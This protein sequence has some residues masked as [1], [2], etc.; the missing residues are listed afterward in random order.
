MIGIYTGKLNVSK[1]EE[2]FLFKKKNL[3]NYLNI[4]E[5]VHLKEITKL[6]QKSLE[7]ERFT[8][9]IGDIFLKELKIEK[10]IYI[11]K[12]S[13]SSYVMLEK[14]WNCSIKKETVFLNKKTEI[15]LARKSYLKTKE[16]KQELFNVMPLSFLKKVGPSKD[17]GL[18]VPLDFPREDFGFIMFSSRIA[19]KALAFKKVIWAIKAVKKITRGLESAWLKYKLGETESRLKK[20]LQEKKE[21]IKKNIEHQEEYFSSLSHEV[22]TPLSIIRNYL[23]DASE[24]NRLDLEAISRQVQSLNQLLESIIFLSK[25][26]SGCFKFNKSFF[27]LY[28]LID[29]IYAEIEL[30]AE[31]RK[32]DF[33]NFSGKDLYFWGDWE[34]IKIALR[35]V[36]MNAVSYCK[37]GGVVEIY[38]RKKQT[39]IKIAVLDTGIG[40]KKRDLNKI[41]NQF[42][43]GS[44]AKILYGQGNGLGLTLAQKIITE[45]KGDIQINSEKNKGTA[46]VIQLF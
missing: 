18:I 44:E 10:I 2:F 24:G 30:M 27:N 26:D 23:N 33:R 16:D 29:E 6:A 13:G 42:Y 46:V 41:F 31:K 1:F 19:G 34:K 22:K 12:H 17:Y 9:L 21:I 32:I 28:D 45:H 7:L 43:R 3:F 38:A 14:K 39:S 37:Q 8:T 11:I 40:I 5:I 35:N 36:I 20:S 25:I 4:R 15:F